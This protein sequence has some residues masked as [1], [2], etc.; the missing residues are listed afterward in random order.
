MDLTTLPPVVPRDPPTAEDV[1]KLVDAFVAQLQ[2][3]E[4]VETEVSGIER[5]D[6]PAEQVI[7]VSEDGKVQ[8]TNRGVERS[9]VDRDREE[10]DV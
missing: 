5:K 7:P 4:K 10:R 3:T 8:R 2:W 6:D 1:N 9:L